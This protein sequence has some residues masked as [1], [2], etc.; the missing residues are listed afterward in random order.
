MCPFRVEIV[1]LSVCL[2]EPDQADRPEPS[3]ARS[4]AAE[5]ERENGPQYKRKGMKNALVTI[6]AIDRT[7]SAWVLYTPERET[8]V[9]VQR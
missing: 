4:T 6:R 8:Y 5:L 1:L 3:V 7:E 2:G 9:G